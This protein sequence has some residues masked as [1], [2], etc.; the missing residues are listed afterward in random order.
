LFI[1]VL[2]LLLFCSFVFCGIF[3]IVGISIKIKGIWFWDLFAL[4]V[5]V[6]FGFFAT[7][8]QSG[9]VVGYE[10]NLFHSYRKTGTLLVLIFGL[11]IYVI[12][13]LKY[14]LIRLNSFSKIQKKKSDLAVDTGSDLKS[15]AYNL[16]I[17]C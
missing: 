9:G 5:S 16:E 1:K 8:C 14:H 3:L 2:D 11:I 12:L 13:K 15:E 4:V 7:S 17:C 10:L 6:L